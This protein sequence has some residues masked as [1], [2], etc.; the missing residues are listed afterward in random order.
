MKSQPTP[1]HNSLLAPLPTTANGSSTTGNAT[2]MGGESQVL[3]D[4]MEDPELWAA[5]PTG[6]SLPVPDVQLSQQAKAETV[7]QQRASPQAPDRPLSSA[8]VSATGQVP[9]QES[10]LPVPD[11]QRSIE[12]SS[13]RLDRS[14]ASTKNRKVEIDE[15]PAS[16]SGARLNFDKKAEA[17]TAADPSNRDQEVGDAM[18]LDVFVD[19]SDKAPGSVVLPNQSIETITA[20]A[21]QQA[22]AMED[23]DGFYPLHGFWPGRK[24]RKRKTA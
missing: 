17:S 9:S 10:A 16:T 20:N 19:V 23:P 7:S 5:V 13:S 8:A 6:S 3:L 15:S 14:T 21:E 4:A 22:E 11:V 24:G 1:S 12:P 18:V 2:D